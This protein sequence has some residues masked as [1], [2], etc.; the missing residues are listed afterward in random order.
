MLP[1]VEIFLLSAELKH[2]V[3]DSSST[4]INTH[5]YND[6]NYSMF[7]YFLNIKIRK[8]F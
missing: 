8:G 1:R 7:T 4:C 2:C 3:W 5:A 6:T